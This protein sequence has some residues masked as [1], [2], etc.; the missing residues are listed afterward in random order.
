MV[1]VISLASY[2]VVVN[3]NLLSDQYPTHSLT[4]LLYWAYWATVWVDLGSWINLRPYNN[5]S[6]MTITF[7]IVLIWSVMSVSDLLITFTSTY[8]FS[9]P[10]TIN[11]FKIVAKVVSIEFLLF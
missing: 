10:P 8:H 2:L 1:L 6:A 7:A 3:F 4:N 9:S 11:Y 5:N